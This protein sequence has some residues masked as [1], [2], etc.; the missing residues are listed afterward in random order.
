MLAIRRTR[1]RNRTNTQI[2][3]LHQLPDTLAMLERQ[4]NDVIKELG[5]DSFWNMPGGWGLCIFYFLCDTMIMDGL[6]NLILIRCR[7]KGL[8]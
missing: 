5:S 4:I 8:V 3:N 1:R 6:I 2:S 7:S